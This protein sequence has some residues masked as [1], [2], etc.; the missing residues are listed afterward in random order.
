[1]KPFTHTITAILILF[2]CVLPE[3]KAQ[4]APMEIKKYYFVDLIP[5][6]DK[7]ELPKAQVDSIQ[8]AHMQNIGQMAKDGILMLAGPF[9][10]GGGIFILKL[11]SMEAA[12]KLAK[13]DPAV[14]AGRLNIKV[15]AWYTGA[16]VFTAEQKK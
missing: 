3:T 4:D 13:N 10:G 15:R 1:M 9:E 6:P 5:N 14:M 7:P 16:G 11:D 8:S 2:I 12:E